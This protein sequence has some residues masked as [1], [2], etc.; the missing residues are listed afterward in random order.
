MGELSKKDA[1][2][3]RDDY[4]DDLAK[5]KEDIR[6]DFEEMDF[7]NAD[8]RDVMETYIEDIE[9]EYDALI[10]MLNNMSFE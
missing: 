1:E 8:Q 10:T 9:S 3:K 2:K 4:V 6:E 5:L 7:V